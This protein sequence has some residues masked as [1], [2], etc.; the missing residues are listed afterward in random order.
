MNLENTDQLIGV[1]AF[2]IIFTAFLFIMR[3]RT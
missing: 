3:D 2:L 1:I